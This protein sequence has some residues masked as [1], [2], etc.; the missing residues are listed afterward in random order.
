MKKILFICSLFYTFAFT[1]KQGNIW[2]FGSHAGLDFNGGIPVVLNNGQTQTL[3]CPGCH[4]EGTSV[5]A[6]SLGNLLFYTDGKTVWNKYHAIMQ[7]GSGLLSNI[8]STQ[9]SLIIPQ[10]GSSRFYYL[11]TVDDFYFDNL[12]YG[13]RY[14]IVDMCLGN[15]V[16][17][18]ISDKKNILILDNVCE[19][20][21]A[22]KHANGIDYWIV[23]HK[24]NSNAFYV[25]PLTSNGIGSPIITNIGSINGPNGTGI[26]TSQGQL[27][28]SP[29]GQKLA[30]VAGNANPGIAECFDFNNNTGVVSNV[31]S[32]VTNPNW[33][34]YGASFSPDNSKLYVSVA[35][36]GNGIYQFD[37]NAGGGNPTTIVSSQ[38]LIAGNYN[39]LGLQLAN[40]GKIYVARS[41]FVG[42]TFLGVINSPNNIGASCSYVNNAIDLNG[43][44]VSYGFPNF[45]DSY[46]YD[47]KPSFPCG[48]GID[49]NNLDNNGSIYPNPFNET[50][51]ISLVENNIAT[52]TVF[53]FLGQAIVKQFVSGET[54]INTENFP[55]GVYYY[56]LKNNEGIFKNGRLIKN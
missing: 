41:P 12:Q 25:Y 14:S 28:A 53:N 17:G 49:D 6:D 4:A 32:L 52:I 8:S 3:G 34:Y 46:D 39:Y 38:T 20:L 55:S 44:D 24:F 13:F 26:G 51:N 33:G 54:L 10:P 43:H 23:V 50:L 16:G 18:V 11:F 35:L 1:Q 15:G 36:N 7:N 5:M 27:K 56:Q 19:K 21:T 45:V 22:V 47:T 42:N 48:V 31:I 40:N 9:S 37:L 2:Y 30:L 29:N